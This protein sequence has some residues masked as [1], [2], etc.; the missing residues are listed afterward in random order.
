MRRKYLG[1]QCISQISHNQTDSSCWTDLIKV[2]EVYLKGRKMIVGDEKKTDFWDDCWCCSEP[3]KV[4]FPELYS[5][6]NE[7][8]LNVSQAAVDGWVFTFRRC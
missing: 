1:D 2:K 4:K 7:Q 3:L 8:H 5:V 6:I